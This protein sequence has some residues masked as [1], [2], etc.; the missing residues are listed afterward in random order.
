MYLD[1]ALVGTTI[2]M[3]GESTSTSKNPPSTGTNE[4]FV[5]CS[6]LVSRSIFSYFSIFLLSTYFSSSE[7]PIMTNVG[8]R[9]E[10]VLKDLA[11][12]LQV[13]FP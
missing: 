1:Q 9:G 10:I 2:G 11:M 12:F 3:L 13:L 4:K 8:A 7:S 6:T 5:G